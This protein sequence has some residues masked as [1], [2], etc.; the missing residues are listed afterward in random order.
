MYGSLPSHIKTEQE[1]K[2][3]RKKTKDKHTLV[4]QTFVF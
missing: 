2:L 4:T 1:K 3:Q